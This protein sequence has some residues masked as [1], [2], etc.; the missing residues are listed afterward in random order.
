MQ[1]CV[2][3]S[4][5]KGNATYI[6]AGGT[7]ILIDGGLSGVEVQR[8]LAAIG[9]DFESLSAILVTHEHNDHIRGVPVLSRRGKLAVFANSATYGGAGKGLDNLY[10][11]HEFETGTSFEWHGLWIHPY[12][13]S[14]DTAD[15]VGF[16]VS[17]G[18]LSMGYCTD[19]GTVSKL[20]A[21]RLSCCQGLV[22]ESNHDLELLHN[23]SYPPF[24][25][26]RVRSNKGHLANGDAAGLLG[27]LAHD[28]LQH[29]V[30]AHI[31][32]SNNR[33]ELVMQMVHDRLGSLLETY[34][35]RISLASQDAPGELVTMNGN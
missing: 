34:S 26:Q 25:K 18:R 19:T 23:G 13:I 24:L 10:A 29:V 11:R 16:V 6:A 32:E 35:F 9:V 20:M 2:L 4:G 1:F 17:D 5:S 33:P 12:S 28:S 31:S 30:L 8:R 15:P 14:H 21:H 3:G 7:A 27:A 22:L